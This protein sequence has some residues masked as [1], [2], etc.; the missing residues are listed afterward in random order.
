MKPQCN[1][2][3][4]DDQ[5][6]DEVAAGGGGERPLGE[7]LTD[8]FEI[9]LPSGRTW[10]LAGGTELHRLAVED[11]NQLERRAA[12]INEEN[13][14]ATCTVNDGRFKEVRQA[15]L[16]N[17]SPGDTTVPRLLLQSLGLCAYAAEQGRR[18]KQGNKK[19]R[20]RCGHPPVLGSWSRRHRGLQEAP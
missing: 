19:E 18:S 8:G 2:D 13:I 11:Y 1:D 3:S 15:S 5:P 20:W 16:P 7:K 17:S 12:E 9:K 4:D 6:D 10:K 14:N